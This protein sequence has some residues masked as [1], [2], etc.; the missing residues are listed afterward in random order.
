MEL[1]SGN[2]NK[3]AFKIKL[4]SKQV[5]YFLSFFFAKILSLSGLW[6]GGGM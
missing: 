2:V 3:N 6:G 4:S 1:I 5:W